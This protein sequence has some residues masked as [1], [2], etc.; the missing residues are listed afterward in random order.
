MNANRS[1]PPVKAVDPVAATTLKNPVVVRP[2]CYRL[3]SAPLVRCS[4]AAGSRSMT[5]QTP[6]PIRGR[7]VASAA[8]VRATN[9]SLVCQYF[10]G[11]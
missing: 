1:D 9:R 11:N 8:E 10:R 2:G 3:V 5:R 4:S 6:L 7:L